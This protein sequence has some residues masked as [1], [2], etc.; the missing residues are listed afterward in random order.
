MVWKRKKGGQRL[1]WEKIKVTLY[2]FSLTIPKVF[3]TDV[4]Q[5]LSWIGYLWELSHFIGTFSSR[6]VRRSAS[7]NRRLTL[8]SNSANLGNSVSWFLLTNAREI[9]SLNLAVYRN[10]IPHMLS[11][12]LSGDFQSFLLHFNLLLSDVRVFHL[13]P[14]SSL[15][16]CSFYWI[17]FFTNSV[18][19]YSH[20]I[21]YSV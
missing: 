12:L 18:Y 4:T 15:C 5:F 6:S 2:K 17:S 7:F 14:L 11:N 21:I 10:K 16:R 1:F 9:L 3:P 8:L 20:L 13:A 19:V